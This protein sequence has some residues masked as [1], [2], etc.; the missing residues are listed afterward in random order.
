MHRWKREKRPN[1]EEALAQPDRIGFRLIQPECGNT[2]DIPP[3]PT[4]RV[5]CAQLKGKKNA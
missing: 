2:M 5:S 4:E 1:E 3:L